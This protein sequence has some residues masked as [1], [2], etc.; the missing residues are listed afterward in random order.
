MAPTFQF[1]FQNS[2]Y[3]MEGSHFFVIMLF[4]N[5]TKTMFKGNYAKKKLLTMGTFGG[6]QHCPPFPQKS[7][8][9]GS[10]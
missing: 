6:T 8:F 7:M 3:V 1:S 4:Q 2:L 10:M 9:I 5:L